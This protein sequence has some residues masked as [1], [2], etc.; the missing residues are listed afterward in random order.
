MFTILF[1][2]HDADLRAVASRV[3]RKN[4]CDVVPVAHAGHATL[5]C[6]ERQD[7]NVIVV[8][9]QMADEPGTAVAERLRRYCP[10]AQLVRMCEED[11]EVRDVEVGIRLVRPFLAGQMIDAVVA[12]AAAAVVMSQSSAGVSAG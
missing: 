12:A 5:A 7:F 1:I 10:G 4:G 9:E 8:E 2:S 6:I 11:A 3:L